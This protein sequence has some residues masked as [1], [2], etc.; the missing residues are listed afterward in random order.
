MCSMKQ[1]CQWTKTLNKAETEQK[2]VQPFLKLWLSLKKA[3]E[4]PKVTKKIHKKPAF[5]NKTNY[6]LYIR[7]AKK[8]LF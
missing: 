6:I 4:K 1:N 7:E 2:P 8:N 3:T 5:S